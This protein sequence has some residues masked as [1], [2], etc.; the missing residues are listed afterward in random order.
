MQSLFVTGTH[1]RASD[2]LHD[3]RVSIANALGAI[4]PRAGLR[5]ALSPGVP[6]ATGG[7][8]TAYPY[9]F[10][11]RDRWPDTFILLSAAEARA[12]PS[13]STVDFETPLGRI[14]GDRRVARQVAARCWPRLDLDGPL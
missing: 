11:D 12:R 6:L 3:A 7:P 14:A 4:A 8:C 13:I 9:A 10:L 1:E 5:G 2:V